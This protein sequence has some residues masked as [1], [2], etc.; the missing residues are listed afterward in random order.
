ML[1]TSL[2]QK[3]G[4]KRSNTE[5]NVKITSLLQ[6]FGKRSRSDEIYKKC[7]TNETIDVSSLLATF[8]NKSKSDLK[9]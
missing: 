5:Q 9:N 7:D 2:E 3:R 6:S 4:I 8:G 1:N